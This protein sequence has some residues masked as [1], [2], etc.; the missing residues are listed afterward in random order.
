[1]EKNW[2]NSASWVLRKRHNI[3]FGF[4][5]MTKQADINTNRNK[6]TGK[7]ETQN[8]HKKSFEFHTCGKYVSIPPAEEDGERRE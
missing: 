5:E 7:Y 6:C 3:D 1:M 8:T 2:Q 4:L